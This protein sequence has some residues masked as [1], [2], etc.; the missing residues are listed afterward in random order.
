MSLSIDN[1]KTRCANVVQGTSEPQ[2]RSYLSTVIAKGDWDLLR[3]D[4][5]TSDI[6]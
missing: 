5:A 3:Y 2:L 4:T 1:A 6:V